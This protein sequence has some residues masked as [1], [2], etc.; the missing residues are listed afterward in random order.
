ME[1]SQKQDTVKDLK[2][3]LFK[4]KNFIYRLE[5]GSENLNLKEIISTDPSGRES[6]VA[7]ESLINRL[8]TQGPGSNKSLAMYKLEIKNHELELEKQISENQQQIQLLRRD[9]ERR[10]SEYEIKLQHSGSSL[11]IPP[12]IELLQFRQN[13]ELISNDD[14]AELFRARTHEAVNKHNHDLSKETPRWLDEDRLFSLRSHDSKFNDLKEILNL[15]QAR[16][17]SVLKEKESLQNLADHTKLRLS[18]VEEENSLISKK[19]EEAQQQICDLQLKSNK[20]EDQYAQLSSEFSQFKERSQA[21]EAKL[22]DQIKKKSLQ[23]EK[24]L[25]KMQQLNQRFLHTKQEL[26]AKQQEISVKVK[27]FEKEKELRE[28]TADALSKNDKHILILKETVDNLLLKLKETQEE[29]DRAQKQLFQKLTSEHNNEINSLKNEHSAAIKKCQ[30]ECEDQINDLK[31][32]HAEKEKILEA[33]FQQRHSENRKWYVDRILEKNEQL[34]KQEGLFYAQKSAFQNEINVLSEQNDQVKLEIEALRREMELKKREAEFAESK[35]EEIQNKLDTSTIKEKVTQVQ[36]KT[37]FKVLNEQIAMLESEMGDRI[38][39]EI[40]KVLLVQKAKRKQLKKTCER[41]IKENQHFYENE[42]KKAKDMVSTEKQVLIDIIGEKE[43]QHLLSELQ[44][45]KLVQNILQ[46]VEIRNSRVIEEKN[47]ILI[48]K[49]LA[50]KKKKKDLNELFQKEVENLKILAMNETERLLREQ[51]ESYK[52]EIK[53]LKEQ[54]KQEIVNK[55]VH[56]SHGETILKALYEKQIK[57]LKALVESLKFD[58]SEA[59]RCNLENEITLRSEI[60]RLQ[61]NF[62]S[63]VQK[64]LELKEKIKLLENELEQILENYESAKSNELDTKEELEQEENIENEISLKEQIHEKDIIINEL[65]QKI[66]QLEV[67]ILKLKESFQSKTEKPPTSFTIIN[68][69][70]RERI[71]VAEE[72]AQLKKEIVSKDEEIKTL[73]KNLEECKRKIRNNENDL[74]FLFESKSP[75][76]ISTNKSKKSLSP[77]KAHTPRGIR[78]RKI[79]KRTLS[80]DKS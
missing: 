23:I 39:H 79:I 46:D 21:Q 50:F 35:A 78:S 4:L 5:S 48:N 72:T 68:E 24:V 11:S 58:T 37:T 38:R 3:N 7:I 12:S 19:Y 51:E 49:K 20:T 65:E 30:T 41:K 27:L 26:D 77:I 9:Y 80:P 1:N 47:Q 56:F 54:Y 13:S 70:L 18:K 6:I 16:L 8:Q 28:Q 34:S 32:K 57:D 42:I 62:E 45:E 76:N 31:K 55:E 2:N 10:I 75:S 43:K 29:A 36:S 69:K 40:T 66:H 59:K 52:E 44:N 53:R 22:E 15:T 64:S 60:K 71:L 73:E 14:K 33:H 63:E 17:Q 61:E 67:E 25:L 74:K